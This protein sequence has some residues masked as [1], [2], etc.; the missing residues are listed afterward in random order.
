MS[1]ILTKPQAIAIYAGMRALDKI[2]VE[3]GRVR[4]DLAVVAWG[5]SGTSVELFRSHPNAKTERETYADHDAFAAA[6][7]LGAQEA[8]SASVDNQTPASPE[9]VIY[10]P[11]REEINPS[12][13]YTASQGMYLRDY[14]AAKI[15]QGYLSSGRGSG[16][17]EEYAKSAYIQAD[18]MMAERAKTN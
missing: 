5:P 12:S 17:S 15:I 13:W 3:T 2:G 16:T 4:V 11:G 6:Y 10:D 7:G 18:A 1:L 9:H 14:F 8:R